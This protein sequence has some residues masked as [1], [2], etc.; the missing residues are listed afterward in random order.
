MSHKGF[1]KYPVPTSG[2]GWFNQASSVAT[3]LGNGVNLWTPK[4]IAGHSITGYTRTAPSTPYTIIA[5]ITMNTQDST[6]LEQIGIGFDDGTKYINLLVKAQANTYTSAWAV[7]YGITSIT[8]VGDRAGFKYAYG[9]PYCELGWLMIR[10]DGTNIYFYV[11]DDTG[12]NYYE[13]YHEARGNSLTTGPTNV[14]LYSDAD[15]S[16]TLDWTVDNWQQLGV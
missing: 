7:Q 1:Y 11:G 12:D 5:H 16:S 14:G 13:V 8:T 9:Y 4:N 2:W 6:G 3:T 15:A 10:D